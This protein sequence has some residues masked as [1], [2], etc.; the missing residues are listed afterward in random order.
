MRLV[1]GQSDDSWQAGAIADPALIHESV[2][3]GAAWVRDRLD[4]IGSGSGR[5]SS[6][7]GRSLALLCLDADGAVC[8]W[9]KPEDADP[10][11]LD[12]AIT[13]AMS[14]IDVDALEPEHHSGIGDRF[15]QMPMELSFEML[16]AD[17][18]STGSRAAVMATPDVVGR[19]LKDQLDAIGVR[20]EKFTTIWHAI[21][22][23]WD[24][25]SGL[26]AQSAQRIVS[27]DAPIAAVIAVDADGG[28]MIWTW[29]RAGRLIASG[30]VRITMAHGQHEN[31]ALIRRDD[32]ARI[33]SDWLGWSSQLGVAPSRI[34]FVGNPARV[35]SSSTADDADSDAQPH[36]GLDA[37]EIG[38]AI[39]KAWPEATIDFIEH[40]DPI[41]ETLSKIASGQRGDGLVSLEALS[42]R[43][44]RA[45]RSMYRW[46][47][48]SLVAVACVIGFM[49]YQ[50]FVQAN[51]IK[52]E[53]KQIKAQ[54]MESINSF[55][56]VL[57][58]SRFPVMDLGAKLSQLRGSQGP[59][60]VARAKPIIEE[61][62]TLSYVFGIP[63][64]EIT[65]IRLNSAVVTVAV[66]VD[67]IRQAEQ[68]DQSLS[69]IKGSN[70]RWRTMTP[71]NVKQRIQATFN[72]RWV[73]E[74]DD[75]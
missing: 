2:N 4:A 16:D 47:G 63:G 48:M 44:G 67:D 25:G 56:P 53:T 73:N 36:T 13:G 55:D 31:L 12:A 9:V 10:A 59:L 37:G 69:K 33:C 64:I 62:E 17:E 8:S 52:N 24:P 46:A 21:A 43:P 5:A 72:A 30:S 60:E 65:S 23:V 29:S 57:A 66:M 75:S 1:S 38:S 68:I 49:G 42:N 40:D 54:R 32:I 41:G 50:L 71:K 39:N 35:E 28:R 14:E 19:L 26:P 22:N 34:V 58:I 6:G 18:T 70:L 27:S 20:V 74:E 45:H 7:K 61:L 15:P 11:M 3:Q 51:G